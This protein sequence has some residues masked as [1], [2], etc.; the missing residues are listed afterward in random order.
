MKGQFGKYF[1]M[2]FGV[3]ACIYGALMLIAS[4]PGGFPT[5]GI[6]L[7]VPWSDTP[8]TI[9]NPQIEPA[10]TLILVG[11]LSISLSSKI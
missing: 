6:I 7:P 2:I 10:V 8:V 1:L 11:V 9:D 4:S 5:L 3:F